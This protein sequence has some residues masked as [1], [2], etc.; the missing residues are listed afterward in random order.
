MA[1]RSI[2]AG[3]RRGG[4]QPGLEADKHLEGDRPKE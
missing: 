2:G 3:G 4:K 1:P